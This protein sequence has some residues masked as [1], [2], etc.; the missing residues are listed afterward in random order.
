VD[1]FY[2]LKAAQDH[3]DGDGFVMGTCRDCPTGDEVCCTGDGPPTAER[4]VD[5]ADAMAA[6]CGERIAALEAENAKLISECGR[7]SNALAA[8]HEELAA[9]KARRCEDCGWEHCITEDYSM[10]YEEDTSLV[11]ME[12]NFYCARWKAKP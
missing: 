10:S 5:A 2:A 11:D 9:L 6:A 4:M 12:D 8:S 3:C 7:R 1:L